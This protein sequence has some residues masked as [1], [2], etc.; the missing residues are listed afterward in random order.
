MAHIEARE[1]EENEAQLQCAICSPDF[2]R[3][4]WCRLANAS[5]HS[6]IGECD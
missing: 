5:T 2:V 4:G 1:T 3:F 6:G